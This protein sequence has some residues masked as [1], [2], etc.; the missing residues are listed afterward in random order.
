[1]VERYPHATWMGQTV[2]NGGKFKAGQPKVLVQHYT[3]AASGKAS[4]DYLFKPHSPASSAHFVIDRDGTIWQLAEINTITWH[5][6]R[7]EWRGMVGLNS[8]AIGIENANLGFMRKTADHNRWL[9][10]ASNYNSPWTGEAVVA[11]HKNGGPEY[12]WE[13][14]PE[15]QIKACLELTEW[16]LEHCPTIREIVGHDDI[17]PGRKSDPGPAFPMNRF[18]LLL[19]PDSESKPRSYKVQASTPLNVR[20]GPG[21]EFEPMKIGPLKDGA[22]VKLLREEG[23]WSFVSFDK[24]EGWVFSQYLAPA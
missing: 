23:K 2:N 9:T 21:T 17:A 20:G 22:T 8:F 15:P 11:R 24:G 13:P 10:A 1:M 3:A 4:A 19:E 18:K 16:L 5:A 14:Y 12:G 7:S 6:G